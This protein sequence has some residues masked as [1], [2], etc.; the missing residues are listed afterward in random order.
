MNDTTPLDALSIAQKCRDA[1]LDPDCPWFQETA[2]ADAEYAIRRLHARI[3]E[4]EAEL[5]KRDEQDAA[6]GAGGVEPLRK[7]DQEESKAVKELVEVVAMVTAVGFGVE[8]AEVEAALPEILKDVRD[9]FCRTD[10][11]A[12]PPAQAQEDARLEAA[13]RVGNCTF[14]AG[15]ASRLVVEAAQ[16]AFE[17]EGERQAMTPEEQRMQERN[18][19]ALWDMVHGP[20]EAKEDARDAERWREVL[21]HVCGSRNPVYGASYFTLAHVVPVKGANIL[22]GSV[23]E[24]FTQAIDAARAAQGGAA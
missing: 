7:R 3:T 5:A 24:H 17:A 23:A 10:L 12:A 22:Q 20:I 6:I 11:Q 18:R 8:P 2:L 14:R 4:L 9:I 15:V 16:R 21:R 1:R 13:A 19:R